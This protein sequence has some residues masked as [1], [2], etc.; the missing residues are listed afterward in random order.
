MGDEMGK[1]GAERIEGL[2][3]VAGDRACQPGV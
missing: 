2:M 3:G 1:W